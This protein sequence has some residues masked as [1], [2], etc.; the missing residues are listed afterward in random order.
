VTPCE[1]GQPVGTLVPTGTVY[2]VAGNPLSAVPV[3]FNSSAN[4]PAGKYRITYVTGVCKFDTKYGWGVSQTGV[5]WRI[6]VKAGTGFT[7]TGFA[8][9]AALD[10]S[11]PVIVN[12]YF[13]G[14]H[15]PEEAEASSAGKTLD[16][17]HNGGALGLSLLD[18]PYYDNVAGSPN[19]TWSLVAL[20]PC[21]V[22]KPAI[23]N[24]KTEC[25]IPFVPAI[26]ILPLIQDCTVPAPPTPNIDCPTEDLPVT[27]PP[28][29]INCPQFQATSRTTPLPPGSNPIVS[30]QNIAS[31][32]MDQ[33]G[34][35]QCHTEIE[36]HFQ[37]P[38]FACPQIQVSSQTTVGSS[39]SMPQASVQMTHPQGTDPCR[40][41]FNFTFNLPAP[42]SPPPCPQLQ[43]TS[44]I[45][46]LDP[47]ATPLFDVKVTPT[48]PLDPQDPC[49]YQ[50]AFQ[51]QV[52]QGYQGPPGPQGPRGCPDPCKVTVSNATPSGFQAA[53]CGMLPGEVL[54]VPT[55]TGFVN[56]TVAS[57]PNTDGTYNVT[58]DPGSN[59]NGMGL[60]AGDGD[61]LDRC[62]DCP[63]ITATASATSTTGPLSASVSVQQTDG[64]NYAFQ[65][66]FQFPGGTGTGYTGTRI[67]EVGTYWDGTTL[68]RT[69]ASDTY[70]DGRLITPGTPYDEDIDTTVDCGGD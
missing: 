44:T 32:T 49:K 59:D 27:P 60:Y 31:N 26:G 9:P 36:F 8:A 61:T 19:P 38:E 28:V 15:T 13:R 58:M 45:S 65:F 64:C 33:C 40:Y 3:Y 34:T 62:Q 53:G 35:P 11:G 20:L 21:Y 66:A 18:D 37:M 10:S 51:L 46:M 14:W 12:G 41:N 22:L 57:T 43:A 6:V 30:V 25:D 69:L 63:Q 5:D 1:A 47:G 52:P 23:F 55:P 17:T 56:G 24:T 67:V 2:T 54:K 48:T 16:F 4:F 39:D 70:Q 29:V 42:P 50:F 7:L 68:H